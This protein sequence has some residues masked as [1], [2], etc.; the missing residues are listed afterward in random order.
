MKI[1]ECGRRTL[2]LPDNLEALTRQPLEDD[3]G[4][5]P[6]RVG[7]DNLHTSPKKE[8]KEKK[9]NRMPSVMETDISICTYQVCS[10]M[11]APMGYFRS[12]PAVVSTHDT[13]VEPRDGWRMELFRRAAERQP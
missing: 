11:H 4:V 6:P 8:K 2:C 3:G 10:S 5:E 1:D 13:M 12:S 7:K 9:V